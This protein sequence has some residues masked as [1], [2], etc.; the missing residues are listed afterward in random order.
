MELLNSRKVE[1]VGINDGKY[2]C[3][4]TISTGKY[5]TTKQYTLWRNMLV[6]TH[7]EKFRQKNKTYI[8]TSVAAEW[9][10]YSNFYEWYEG[11]GYKEPDWQLDKDILYK[12]NKVYSPETCCFVPVKINQVI[13]GKRKRIGSQPSGVSF[14]E[15]LQKFMATCSNLEGRRVYLGIFET[16]QD[17]FYV[18]KN[19]KQNIFREM[20]S[21]YKEKLRGDVYNTLIN[22]EF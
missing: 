4:E 1:G 21:T 13:T 10:Y 19:Y 22:Y 15:D 14:R 9:L 6:R 8:G 17:A 5:K 2:P 12:N 11:Y 3:S 20:L 7:N 16:E 18:Y